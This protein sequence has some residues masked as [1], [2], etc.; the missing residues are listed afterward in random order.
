[1]RKIFNLVNLIVAI[2]L[3]LP[4]VAAAAA[5]NKL[6]GRFLLQVQS[7]GQLWYV[8]PVDHLRHMIRSGDAAT[9]S[10]MPALQ[11]IDQ[12]D[13][14]KIPLAKLIPAAADLSAIDSDNDGIADNIEKLLGTDPNK[15]DTDLDGFSD[16]TEILNGYN[17][18]GAGKVVADKKVMAVNIGRIVMTGDSN[19]YIN[20]T[21]SRRYLIIDDK[22]GE[23]KKQ[24]AGL[25]VGIT[26]S[27]LNK[28]AVVTAIKKTEKGKIIDCGED[29]SCMAK[30]AAKCSPARIKYH[31]QLGDMSEDVVD[32]VSKDSNGACKELSVGSNFKIFVSKNASAAEKATAEAMIDGAKKYSRISCAGTGEQ[33]VK[34]YQETNIGEFSGHFSTDP[35]DKT[36]L[37]C[38]TG[39]DEAHAV[40]DKAESTPSVAS[41]NEIIISNL[42]YTTVSI[43]EL[44]KYLDK[45]LAFN[46]A[47]A[48][49][50]KE[51]CNTE[52]LLDSSGG[53]VF[54]D[55]TICS[56]YYSTNKNAYSDPVYFSNLNSAFSGSY[57]NR[58]G[59]N[60]FENE[61]ID[62]I[63][64]SFYIK[65]ANNKES[66]H[67]SLTITK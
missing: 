23:L 64:Y 46:V 54:D 61:G 18:L 9:M 41:A 36:D 29:F 43:S 37:V 65:D 31:F 28:I 55:H 24:L 15:A 8:S 13:L 12:T 1:M 50:A 2:T 58:D 6:D 51:V 39:Y 44:S 53:H 22:S 10:L 67:L 16:K 7:D 30:A 60:Y 26:N 33:L 56:S 20:P 47:N 52:S 14:N 19:W 35:N 45:P 5:T 21:D 62:H 4:V 34:K 42:N 48:E 3:F 27:D 17:P 40:S 38:N 57:E 32:E 11:M 63:V 25:A 66:N 59:K 49:L